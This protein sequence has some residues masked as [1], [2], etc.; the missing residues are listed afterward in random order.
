MV[1]TVDSRYNDSRFND[2]L[3]ITTDF[4]SPFKTLIRLMYFQSRFNDNKNLQ[5]LD[6]TTKLFVNPGMV[7]IVRLV[8]NRLK[9]NKPNC[10]VIKS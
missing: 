1:N 2:T 8:L 4:F 5:T 6:L 3:D 10:L 9:V 7:F